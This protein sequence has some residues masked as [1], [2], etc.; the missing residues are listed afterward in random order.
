MRNASSLFS[1][2]FPHPFFLS[3]Y[4]G[5]LKGTFNLISANAYHLTY[6]M[7]YPTYFIL[8]Q[9]K[10]M[11]VNRDYSISVQQE[12]LQ[13]TKSFYLLLK[14]IQI[15]LLHI[16]LYRSLG[17]C[18]HAYLLNIYLGVEFLALKIIL[19]GSV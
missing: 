3:L 9:E 8:R 4:L 17:A 6:I 16:F 13:G 10:H 11:R 15:A 12:D 18:G 2:S 19:E 7:L 14:L 1:N 5:L